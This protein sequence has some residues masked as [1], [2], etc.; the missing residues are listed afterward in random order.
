MEAIGIKSFG[1]KFQV[2]IHQSIAIAIAYID[3]ENDVFG[4]QIGH[5]VQ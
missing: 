2:C 5:Q 4:L 1:Q 3:N